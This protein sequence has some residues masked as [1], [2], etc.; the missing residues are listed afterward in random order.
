VSGQHLS[1]FRKK[2]IVPMA[3]KEKR[4]PVLILVL[5]AIKMFADLTSFDGLW[6][7]W[8]EDLQQFQGLAAGLI[9]IVIII[10]IMKAPSVVQNFSVILQ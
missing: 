9:I 5:L 1:L 6:T 8:S 4:K 2:K 10:T 7:P 3:D